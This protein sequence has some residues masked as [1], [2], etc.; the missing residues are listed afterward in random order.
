MKS[1]TELLVLP[2]I[3]LV[4]SL[5][6]DKFLCPFLGPMVIDNELLA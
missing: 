5:F 1:A 2:E 4:Q 6:I 3:F